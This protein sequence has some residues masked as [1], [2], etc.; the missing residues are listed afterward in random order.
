MDE[1]EPFEGEA[2]ERPAPAKAHLTPKLLRA[3][4]TGPLTVSDLARAVDRE[5][6]N[7]SVTRAIAALC[8]SGEV[9]RADDK[10][11]R[12]SSFPPSTTP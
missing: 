8:K 9:E 7:G 10:R 3:L 1:A 4:K 2:P 5:P 12:L 11:Y 6:G